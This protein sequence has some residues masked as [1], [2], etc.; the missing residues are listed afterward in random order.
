MSV[1]KTVGIW[2][3]MLGALAALTTLV[4]AVYPVPAMSVEVIG[5][6]EQDRFA[7]TGA[8]FLPATVA[9]SIRTEAVT[10]H[11]C[12]WKVTA[13]C[14]RDDQHGDAGC[15]GTV[16]GCP[17]GREIGRAW[18]A[19]PGGDFEPVGLFC[20]H[21]GEVT[22]VSDMNNRV[23]GDMAN[24]VPRLQ[25]QCAPERGVVVGIEVHCRSGQ[26]SA[27]QAWTN[28]LAGYSVTTTAR[29]TWE[30]TFRQRIPMSGRSAGSWVQRVDY[31]GEV[32]PG[33]GI[34]QAFTAAG[35]HEIAVRATWLGMY[36]VDGLGPFP[37]HEAVRQEVGWQ[38]PVGSALGVL[39]GP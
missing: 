21:D 25:P 1:T 12:Q 16:L 26:R 27:R 29:A 6:D 4:S 17:Q 36:T 13:P 9:T 38:V 35:R 19:R 22:S 15:R 20:P 3:L 11:G 33:S 14:L 32:Y 31:P 18:L 8:V 34:R 30:W 7:G 39:T 10:C 37:V 5:D 24:R 23:R 28:Q 2:L